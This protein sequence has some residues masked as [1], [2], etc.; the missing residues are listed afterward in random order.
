MATLKGQNFR[1]GTIVG[2]KYKVFG[3]STSCSVTRNT[4]TDDESTKDD[5]GMASKPVITS[6]S[7]QVQVDSLNVLDMGAML[8]AIKNMT[9]FTLMWDETATADNQTSQN[10]TFARKM[11]AYL[12]DGTFTF[13][14]RENAAKSLQFQSTGPVEKIT[15][16]LT[17]EIVSAGSYTK[18]QFVRLFLSDD[19]SAAPSKVIAAAR[20]LSFHVSVQLE[21][22]TTKDT[23]GDY[24]VQEPTGISFDISSNALVRSS[25]TITSAVLAQDFASIED[26]YEAGTPVKFQIANVSGANQRTKGSVIVSGSVI[27]SQLQANSPNKQAVDFTTSLTGYGDYTVGS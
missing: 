9:P 7:C 1:L 4:N 10:A 27:I 19:N 15:T 18:G 11:S 14:D 16:A 2:G 5:V 3:M 23:E 20:Q 17:T 25:D 26:L 24:D 13:N 12:N 8:T 21:Q 22:A 6:K